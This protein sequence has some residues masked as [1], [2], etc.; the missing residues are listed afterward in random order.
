MSSS[1]EPRR[2]ARATAS[3]RSFLCAGAALLAGGC[4]SSAE[5]RPPP[6]PARPR[7]E[8]GRRLDGGRVVV[9]GGGLAGLAVAFELRRRGRE[10]VVLEAQSR[11][12]GRIL[13]VRQPMPE[14]QRVEAGA[15]HVVGDPDLLALAEAAGIPVEARPRPPQPARPLGQVVLRGGKRR[16]YPDEDHVPPDAELTAEETALGFEGR[17]RRF[18]PDAATLD[19]YTVRFGP[20]HLA[21]DRVLAADYLREQGASPGLVAGYDQAFGVGD[22]LAHTSALSLVRDV[23]NLLRERTLKGGGRFA[24]GS[25]GLPVALAAKLGDQG[26]IREAAVRRIVRAGA[27]LSVTFERRGKTEV[28]GASRVVC[29]VPSPVLGEIDI[30]PPLPPVLRRAMAE[31]RLTAV[32]RVWIVA[33]R[34]VW[35]ERGEAGTADTDTWIGRV[36]DETEAQS[37]LAGVLGLYRSGASAREMDKV[38]NRGDGLSGKVVMD[39][40]ERVHPGLRETTRHVLSKSWEEDE[41]QRGAYAAFAPGQLTGYGPFAWAPV[42]ALHF[43]GDHTSHRP[44]FMHGAVSSAKRVLGEIEADEARLSSG[45]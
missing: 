5:E 22:G 33:N 15:T 25:D 2:G 7:I 28:L 37:G 16:V 17:L 4:V 35:L 24:G 32:T 45:G 31:L 9:V 23:A 11:V 27:E 43:A 6:A 1:N 21:L 3:R 30:A 20:Q 40:M 29:A 34:R 44:G 13:T 10:V 8:G 41:C 14:G 19:P 38:F 18:I 26:V 36:R 39:A 12:G 42:G